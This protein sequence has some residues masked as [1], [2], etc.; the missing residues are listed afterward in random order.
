VAKLTD[1][2]RKFCERAAVHGNLTRAADEASYAHPNVVGPRLVEKPH[3]RAYLEKLVAKVQAKREAKAIADADEVLTFL[4][5]MMRGE[6]RDFEV[7][8]SGDVEDTPVPASERRKAAMDVAKILGLLR[9]KVEHSGP[10]GQPIEL[11][12]YQEKSRAELE[13][14]ARKLLGAGNKVTAAHSGPAKD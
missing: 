6:V 14:E 4:T 8:L 12:A 3:V 1:K 7:T 5:Q 2:Q 9:D 11:K 13:A 10:N